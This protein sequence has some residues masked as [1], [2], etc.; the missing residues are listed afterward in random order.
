MQEP[1]SSLGKEVSGRIALPWLGSR[2][3]RGDSI[4]PGLTPA[5]RSPGDNQVAHPE[6]WSH[7]CP[8]ALGL[9]RQHKS[10]ALAGTG[11][12]ELCCWEC[13][14]ITTGRAGLLSA[15]INLN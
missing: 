13:N 4:H 7:S 3:G 1:P 11:V 14:S 12:V 2:V 5:L 8:P 9:G 6:Q 10:L 15:V